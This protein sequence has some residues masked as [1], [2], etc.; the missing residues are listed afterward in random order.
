MSLAL[1]G[2]R[3]YKQLL[4]KCMHHFTHRDE[5]THYNHMDYLKL[6]DLVESR[7]RI[8]FESLKDNEKLLTMIQDKTKTNNDYSNVL[9]DKEKIENRLVAINKLTKK[10]YED[11]IIELI[12]E[13]SYQTI[14]KEY[15]NE[16]KILDDKLIK[17]NQM[18]HK[19]NDALENFN[20]LKE[21]MNEFLDFKEL[22]KEMVYKLIDRIDIEHIKEVDGI[23][24]KDINITYRF[25]NKTL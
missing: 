15:Q 20:K 17:I 14:I 22:T 2:R 18:N 3:K 12:S 10:I 9:A 13:S 6:K 8:L 5:C 16:Q 24:T 25:I 1:V 21:V 11:Y 23:K 4:Y 19:T 7:V